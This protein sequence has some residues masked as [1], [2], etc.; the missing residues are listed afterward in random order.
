MTFTDGAQG[1]GTVDAWVIP[2]IDHNSGHIVGVFAGALL[3][4]GN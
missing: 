2:I 4:Q 3:L 1:H